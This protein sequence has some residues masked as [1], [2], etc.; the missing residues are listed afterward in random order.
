MAKNN[1]MNLPLTYKGKLLSRKDNI[2]YYGN[3]EDDYIIMMNVTGA[4]EVNGVPVTNKVTVSLQT[5]TGGKEREIKKVER[6]GIYKALDIAEFWLADALGEELWSSV[7][8]QFYSVLLLHSFFPM[9]QFLS[10]VYLLLNAVPLMFLKIQ[11]ECIK[12]PFHE[13]EVLLYFSVL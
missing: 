7:Y 9:F 12:L 2:I 3:P 11:E 8:F 5:N 10:F 6:D 13:W 1:E 4:E